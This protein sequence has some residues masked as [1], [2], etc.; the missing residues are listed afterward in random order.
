MPK[1]K[2]ILDRIMAEPEPMTK[3]EVDREMRRIGPEFHEQFMRAMIEQKQRRR[4]RG[5]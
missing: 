4:G 5:D 3:A 1:R 2:S